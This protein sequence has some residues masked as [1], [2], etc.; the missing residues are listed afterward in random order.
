M[1]SFSFSLCKIT[2]NNFRRKAQRCYCGAVSCRGLIG[3]QDSESEGEGSGA[4]PTLSLDDEGDTE[5]EL[6]IIK[7]KQLKSGR[8]FL[9]D[10]K[11]KKI[12]RKQKKPHNKDYEKVRM[13][14][15]SFPSFTLGGIFY[16]LELMF[17]FVRLF[18]LKFW[19]KLW[20]F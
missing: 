13:L 2:I 18:A 4:S 15:R 17:V 14:N 20:S 1:C 10:E 7:E 12:R 9:K 8:K 6:R 3:E 19:I 16:W 5:E 11:K